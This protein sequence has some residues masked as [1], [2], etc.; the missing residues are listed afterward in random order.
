LAKQ[1]KKTK[2]LQKRPDL[3]DDLLFVWESFL[4][5]S[6]GRQ[7]SHL[8]PIT[9]TE[10]EAYF[11]I[12]AIPQDERIELVRWIKFIDNKFLELKG[13]QIQSNIKKST[14]TKTRR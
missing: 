8:Q 7:I 1:G 13:K 14:V 10:M 11:N 3:F 5:L 6:S 9:F 2:A 12:C 4:M